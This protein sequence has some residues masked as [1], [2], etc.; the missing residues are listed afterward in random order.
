M[1]LGGPKFG[2]PRYIL[3][4]DKSSDWGPLRGLMGIKRKL[5]KK[6]CFEKKL[7][8]KRKKKN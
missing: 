5:K 4:P 8:L 6:K 2:P 7:G 3:S 1:F